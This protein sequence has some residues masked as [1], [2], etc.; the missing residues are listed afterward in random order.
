MGADGDHSAFARHNRDTDEEEC[1]TEKHDDCDT[2][3][4]T[5]VGERRESCVEN[6]TGRYNGNLS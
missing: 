2:S 6:R 5:D 3:G 1:D 4:G